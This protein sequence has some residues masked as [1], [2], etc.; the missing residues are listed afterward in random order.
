MIIDELDRCHPEFAISFLESTKL[1]FGHSG[2]VFCLMVNASYLENLAKHRFGAM[3]D[4]E[5]YLDKFV[6]IR[7]RLEQSPQAFRE[8]VSEIV[9][10]MPL[11]VPFG[12]GPEFSV[13]V[14]AQLASDLAAHSSLSMRKVKRVL[15][16]VEIALRCYSS[17][18]IDLPLLVL[19]AFR[20]E[21]NDLDPEEWLPRAHFSPETAEAV[22]SKYGDGGQVSHKEEMRREASWNQMIHK[23]A[24]E[25][26]SLPKDRYA[27]P[28][29][30][31]Y[32][33]WALV[34]KYLAPH[35]IPNH[36]RILSGVASVLVPES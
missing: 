23:M 26:L 1:I 20:E 12:E 33:D 4:D 27:T 24:P 34:L 18:P 29:D 14:A 32:K 22:L 15:L 2:F 11:S 17:H 30:R 7:L 25:L 31:N 13:E 36:L 9:K 19:L 6:D 8:A 16:K 10:E 21:R 5:K 35:Y 28:E 3:A